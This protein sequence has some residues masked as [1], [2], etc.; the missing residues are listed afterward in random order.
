TL[1]RFELSN[2][3]EMFKQYLICFKG[4]AFLHVGTRYLDYPSI[5]W[6]FIMLVALYLPG[7]SSVKLMS[8]FQDFGST[9]FFIDINIINKILWEWFPLCDKYQVTFCLFY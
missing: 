9:H 7:Y 6:C 5:E 2:S 4:D 3:C 8:C 1:V